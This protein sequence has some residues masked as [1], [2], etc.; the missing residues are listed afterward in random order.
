M[1]RIAKGHKCIQCEA[2]LPKRQPGPYQRGKMGYR[3]L[4]RG[5]RRR[6]IQS[7]PQ[8]HGSLPVT[9][10]LQQTRRSLENF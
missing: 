10:C 8:Y 4:Y 5:T 3:P 6:K 7:L 9:P 1:R 2:D